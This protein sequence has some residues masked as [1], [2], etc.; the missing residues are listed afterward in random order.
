VT[1]YQVIREGILDRKALKRTADRIRK[2]YGIGYL[3]GS[4]TKIEASNSAREGY[5]SY[6]QYLSPRTA[7]AVQLTNAFPVFVRMPQK[8][9]R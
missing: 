3:L 4:S 8:V 9:A 7:I 6:I 5:L 1:I 2:D